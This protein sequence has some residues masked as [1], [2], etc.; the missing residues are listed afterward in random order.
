MVFKWPFKKSANKSKSGGNDFEYKIM[1]LFAGFILLVILAFVTGFFKVEDFFCFVKGSGFVGIIGLFFVAIIA[2]ASLFFPLPLDLLLAPISVIE[3]LHLGI[4]SP[5]LLGF[6]V[7]LGASIGEFSGYV[8]GYLGITTFNK[9]K[10]QEIAQL[11]VLR[12][13][14][15]KVGIPLLI[16]FAFT[17]LP[18]DVIGIAAGLAKYSK[19][20]FF[21]GC[22]LGKFPRYVL[23]A[24]AGYFGIA[25]ILSLFGV[26]ADYFSMSCTPAIIS[27]P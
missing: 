19:V 26:P 8:I 1:V 18:F 13:Q 9:M 25:F 11:K 5:L 17:P 3:F 24:Y 4:F 23:I 6:V 10:K 14:L 27:L 22:F 15:N 12:D 2:N 21:I 7:A 16:I 20:K